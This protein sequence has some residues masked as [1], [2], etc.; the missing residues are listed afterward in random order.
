MDE[1]EDNYCGYLSCTQTINFFFYLI[2]KFALNC[3]RGR[4]FI[5]KDFYIKL[6]G[7]SSRIFEA[8]NFM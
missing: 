3:A 5:V 1:Y 7:F 8:Q 4:E 2:K 6:E